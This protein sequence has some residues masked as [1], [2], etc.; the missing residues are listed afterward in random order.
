MSSIWDLGKKEQL[1]IDEKSHLTLKIVPGQNPLKTL[2]KITEVT[3]FWGENYV[4]VCSHLPGFPSTLLNLDADSNEEF[5]GLP[6]LQ[7]SF[8]GI[9]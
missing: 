4:K 9:Y 3:I 6:E 7:V 8:S 5:T 2:E 1:G